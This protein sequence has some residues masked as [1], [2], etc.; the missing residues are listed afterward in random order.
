MKCP[1]IF[2]TIISILA[3]NGLP[4]NENGPSD[5]HRNP[6]LNKD[7]KTNRWPTDDTRDPDRAPAR[8]P[9][10]DPYCPK[11]PTRAFSK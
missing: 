1:A 10:P 5:K 2:A 9:N 7:D 6:T 3:E 4:C 11:S 8:N